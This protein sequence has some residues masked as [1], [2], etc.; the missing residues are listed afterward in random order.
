[1]DRF[2]DEYILSMAGSGM[3]T[4]MVTGI[5]MD[6]MYGET[7]KANGQPIYEVMNAFLRYKQTHFTSKTC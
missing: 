5:H 6:I 7:G 2:S 1:M 4:E 3:C